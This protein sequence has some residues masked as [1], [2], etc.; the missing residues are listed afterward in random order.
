MLQL[1]TMYVR[2]SKYLFYMLALFVLGWGFTPYK[3]VFLGL[4]FGTAVGLFNLWI[5]FRKS[6]R[7]GQA[8]EKKKKMY[9]M[10]MSM[11]MMIAGVSVFIAMRYPDL[12]HLYSVVFGL[13]TS[14]IVI[15]IDVFISKP[16]KSSGEER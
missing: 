12:F 13:M 16:L 1:E 2:Q 14:Y 5:L 8:I 7:I 3:K 6:K 15:L 11:R 10:G 4:I 9:S